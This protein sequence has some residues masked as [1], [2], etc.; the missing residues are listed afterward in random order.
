M[1]RNGKIE[2]LRFLFGAAI[3]ILHSN[4]F[5]ESGSFFPRASL[6]VDFFCLVSGYLMAVSISKKNSAGPSADLG[7]ETQNFLKRKIGALMPDFLIAY[8]IGFCVMQIRWHDSGIFE[9]LKRF[10]RCIWEPLFLTMAGFGDVRTNGVDWYLSAMILSMLVLYPLCRKYFSMFTRVIGPILA[11]LIL[12]YFYLEYKTTVSVYARVGLNYKGT[13]RVFAE[14]ALGASCY[15]LIQY[16]Q[17]LRLTK[18][19]KFLISL[20]EGSIY[21][22][23]FFYM[24]AAK[25]ASSDFAC[26]LL[27]F[28]GTCLAWSQQGLFSGCFNNQLCAFLGKISLPLYLSHIYWGR[29]VTICFPGRTYVETLKIYLLLALITTVFIYSVSEILRRNKEKIFRFFRIAF[30]AQP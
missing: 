11:F 30:L 28:V 3:V 19:A 12:G 27:I 24:A 5:K 8:V 15:P 25:D 7:K 17:G 9:L 14:I 13:L 2:L 26:L 18:T 4:T 10:A 6:G 21:G 20:A 1:K 22:M 16:L 29:V 23:I